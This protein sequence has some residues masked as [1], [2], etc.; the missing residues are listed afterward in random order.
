MNTGK[1]EKMEIQRSTRKLGQ[2]PSSASHHSER[3]QL[4][5]HGNPETT[6]GYSWRGA[7]QL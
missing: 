1:N 2:K 3:W 4:A 5:Q 7:A 6:S